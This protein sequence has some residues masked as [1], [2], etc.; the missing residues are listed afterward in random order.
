[1]GTR[2]QKL[3]MG[4]IRLGNVFGAAGSPASKSIKR[5]VEFVR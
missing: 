2:W 4:V 1:M 5:I 3:D